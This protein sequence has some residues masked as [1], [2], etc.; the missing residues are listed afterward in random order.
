[1]RLY[2]AFL[3]DLNA[4]APLT[5]TD[6]A[7]VESWWVDRVKQF[8]A[9]KP[10]RLRFDASKSLR[11]IVEDLI[12]QALRR[13]KDRPGTRMA[14]PMLQHLVGAKLEVAVPD[15]EIQHHGASVADE[16]S[17][18]QG[19]FVVDRVV[20]H[21]T[22]APSEALAQKC[23]EN[24]N[25]GLRPIIVTIGRR[26]AGAQALLSNNGIE[27]RVDVFDVEQF[28]AMNVYEWSRFVDA[29]RV[30]SV[31]ELVSRYNQIIDDCETDPGLKIEVVK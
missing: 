20:L 23:E 27:G 12:E 1:M 2:V 31:R 19:D 30:V 22:T 4:K 26:V 15:K 18:R 17:E 10:F 25:E 29:E 16:P 6:L 9:A 21:T 8:L 13:E 3:N 5:P 28:I 7:C 14:G 24:L 11:A